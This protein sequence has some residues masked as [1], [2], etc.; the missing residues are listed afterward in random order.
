VREEI[1][2]RSGESPGIF[3]PSVDVGSFGFGRAEEE[4]C[5]MEALGAVTSKILARAPTL[6]HLPVKLLLVG[7]K[8]HR[9]EVVILPKSKG[10]EDVDGPPVGLG[11]PIVEFLN[12]EDPAFPRRGPQGLFNHESFS[13]DAPFLQSD[14]REGVR[15]QEDGDAEVGVI[16]KVFKKFVANDD[17]VS[18]V[19]LGLR[20]QKF[21]QGPVPDFDSIEPLLIEVVLPFNFAVAE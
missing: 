13:G 20:I 17:M 3:P 2:F 18:A 21:V 12:N 8:L 7:G 11:A 5:N 1:F 19:L 9:G 16:V 4:G 6:V 15:V 10:K 14:P